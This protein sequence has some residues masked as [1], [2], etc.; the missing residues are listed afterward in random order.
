MGIDA[1]GGEEEL[2]SAG[3]VGAGDEECAVGTGRAGTRLEAIAGD[4]RG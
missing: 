1:T 2:G 3:A 4:S